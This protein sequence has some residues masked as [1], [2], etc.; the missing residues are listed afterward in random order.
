MS[1]AEDRERYMRRQEADHDLIRQRTTAPAARFRSRGTSLSPYGTA[2]N[3]LDFALD[4]IDDA[5][6]RTDFLESWR[7]ND[8]SEWP[9]YASWLH[10]NY[11]N[12]VIGIGERPD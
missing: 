10:A 4:H 12:E 5:F 1:A 2:Q 6:E 8:V 3:A 9:E 7:D 11:R